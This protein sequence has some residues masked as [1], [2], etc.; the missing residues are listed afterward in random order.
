M[1]LNFLS[2]ERPTVNRSTDPNIVNGAVG[3][4]IAFLEDIVDGISP[5]GSYTAIMDFNRFIQLVDASSQINP[6]PL[7]NGGL[8]SWDVGDTILVQGYMNLDANGIPDGTW[9]TSKYTVESVYA[10]GVGQLG[11]GIVIPAPTRHDV[12]SK[13]TAWEYIGLQYIPH[14]GLW[15]YAYSI[16]NP[17]LPAIPTNPLIQG[18]WMLVDIHMEYYRTKVDQD[19]IDKTI[20]N[21][22]TTQADW[23]CEEP[24]IPT[25]PSPGSS[26]LPNPA[27][28]N[29]KPWLMP[30]VIEGGDWGAS[31]HVAYDWI[32]NGGDWTD[33]NNTIPLVPP[34]LNWA[35]NVTPT[36]AVIRQMRGKL[37]DSNNNT[38]LI[39]P[40]SDITAYS[41]KFADTVDMANNCPAVWVFIDLG[42]NYVG[43]TQNADN[44]DPNYSCIILGNL[45]VKVITIK[46]APT[47]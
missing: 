29:N 16:F 22:A 46:I 23:H 26:F 39:P 10:N 15:S 41:L 14:D 11:T 43:V 17:N 4:Q 35:Q 40:A 34:D 38:Y 31:G 37:K 13:Y 9:S 20:E 2:S 33:P 27:F 36:N 21:L 45:L 28:I 3:G 8:Y 47:P 25:P 30:T 44:N 18:Q 7:Q 6:L 42:S 12:Q 19:K 1:K 5:Q 24:T 32:V